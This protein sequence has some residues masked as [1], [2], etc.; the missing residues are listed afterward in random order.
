MWQR[1]IKVTRDYFLVSHK[2]AKGAIVLLLLSITIVGATTTY[3][4]W[5]VD[6]YEFKPIVVETPKPVPTT[7]KKTQASVPKKQDNKV[8][9]SQKKEAIKVDI[10][11]ADS[12][13]LQNLHGIGKKL[14]ARIVKY[15]N[16]LGGFHSTEQLREVYG[17]SP[18]YIESIINHTFLSSS[19]VKQLNLNN[20]SFKDLVHHP[21]LE[22]EQVKKIFEHKQRTG[23]YNL[24]NDLKKYDILPE[25]VYQK[26]KPYLTI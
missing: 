26:V 11:S 21:Y 5:P 18:E 9:Q 20:A 15:R 8:K 22:Y 14:A 6:S 16:K 19:N 23:G 25:N 2:E 17:I 24:V 3:R 4:N 13:Q 1:M 10:S 12:I 7:P